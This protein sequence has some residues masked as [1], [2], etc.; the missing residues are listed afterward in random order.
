M[1]CVFHY[2]EQEKGSKFKSY[3]L[4]GG[5]S[6]KDIH[7]HTIYSDG[8]ST[9]EEIIQNAIKNGLNTVGISD[10]NRALFFREPE[11]ECLYSYIN[12]INMLKQY[13]R[14]D[15]QVLMG[16]ELNLNFEYDDEIDTISFDII[17]TLDYIL[18]EHLDGTAPSKPVTQF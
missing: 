5:L 2:R 12:E 13:Y 10:H 9:P 4:I 8:D 1:Y 17:R 18:L 11:Y 6:I 15:I 3:K 7:N 16:I 14:N